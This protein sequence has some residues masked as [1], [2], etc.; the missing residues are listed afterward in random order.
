L[1]DRQR[2]ASVGLLSRLRGA[3]EKF[4]SLEPRLRL[5]ARGWL[6]MRAARLDALDG[7]LQA[8]S[9]QAVLRRGYTMTTL[10]KTGQILRAAAALKPGDRL[11]TRFADGEA[12][13]VVHDSRQLSLFE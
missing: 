12:E 10:K 1:D 2:A 13:S 7:R 4:T 5:V 8:L 11:I 6:A 3:R 9:P